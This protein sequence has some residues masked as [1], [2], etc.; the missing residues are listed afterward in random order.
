MN[1]RWRRGS[2]AYR[3]PDEVIQTRA[4]EIVTMTERDM[5]AFIVSAILCYSS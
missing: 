5:K 3:V 1:Q 4:Y 2:A